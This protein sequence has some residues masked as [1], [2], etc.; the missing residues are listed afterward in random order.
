MELVYEAPKARDASPL[1]ASWWP[2]KSVAEALA[3]G[4]IPSNIVGMVSLVIVTARM[5]VIMIMAYSNF[6]V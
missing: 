2:S 6:M 4:G 3:V 5:E 1:R